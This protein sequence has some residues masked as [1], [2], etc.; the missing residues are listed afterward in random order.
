MKRPGLV[1]LTVDL[2]ILFC[3]GRPG[4]CFSLTVSRWCCWNT[5]VSSVFGVAA[6]E[7]PSP[8][9]LPVQLYNA[10]GLIRTSPG[11]R[12]SQSLPFLHPTPQALRFLP[13]PAF[14]TPCHDSSGASA[15]LPRFL[16]FLWGWQM[17]LRL[18][19]LLEEIMSFGKGK[20]VCNTNLG[21]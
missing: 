15:C 21:K 8:P 19:R 18:S 3:E 12:C 7:T 6:A 17:K 1:V 20:L 13:P 2:F 10:V 14:L 5:K 4:T 11:C 9:A 16:S